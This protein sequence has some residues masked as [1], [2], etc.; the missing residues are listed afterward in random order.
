MLHHDMSCSILK[1]PLGHVNHG[2]NLIW[3]GVF[4][5]ILFIKKVVMV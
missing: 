5:F 1:K 4:K 3:E 2:K